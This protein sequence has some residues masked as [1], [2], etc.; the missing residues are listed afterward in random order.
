MIDA[1]RGIG[2]VDEEHARALL[3]LRHHDADARAQRAGD[4]GLAAVHHPVIAVEV[5]GR[6]HHRRVGP[7]SAIFGGFGHEEGGADAALDHRLQETVLEF[8]AALL[9]EQIHIALVGCHRV[10]RER[11]ER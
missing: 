10:A 3:G 11:A 4:K 7:G 6:L 2:Q 8:G 9:A 1:D 5:T